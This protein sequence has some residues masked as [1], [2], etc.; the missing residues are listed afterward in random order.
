MADSKNSTFKAFFL[1]MIVLVA[2]CVVI[3]AAMAAI[4]MLT[5]PKIAKEQQRKEQE[6]LSAVVPDNQGFEEIALKK[7]YESV[8]SLYADKGSDALAVMLSVKGYDASNPMS[9]A[10][11]FDGEGK[12]IKCSVISCAGETKGIGSKVSTD[13]FLSRFLGKSDVSSVDTI[14]GATIS[15]KAFKKAV[16]EAVLAVKDYRTAEVLK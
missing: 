13:D 4:N 1:P 6:A 9:V 5:A 3:G 16:D 11:G 15:S 8:V 12:I 14:S 2:I 7:E 10:V